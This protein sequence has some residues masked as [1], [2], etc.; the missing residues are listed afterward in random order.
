MEWLEKH[1]LPT[2]C[3]GCPEEDCYNCDTAGE[4]W[5]LTEVDELRLRR[6]GLERSIEHMQRQLAEIDNRL[7]QIEKAL[8]EPNVQMTQEMWESCLWACIQADDM[9]QYN[10]LWNE[11]PDLADNMMREFYEVAATNPVHLSEEEIRASW[12]RF[13]TMMREKYGEEFI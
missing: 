2:A 12:E 13:K 5:Y 4:R 11:L 9:E 3:Q 1:P 6:K 10:R 8:N 7:A